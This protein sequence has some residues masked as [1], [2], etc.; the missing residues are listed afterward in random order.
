IDQVVQK[1]TLNTE[2]ERAFMIIANHYLTA[3]QSPLQLYMAGMAG[4]GKSRVIHALSAFFTVMDASSQLLL[5]APTGTA[6]ANIGGS[7]YHSVLGINPRSKSIQ[8]LSL[9]AR[10]SLERVRYIFIDEVSMI[11][12]SDMKTISER[13]AL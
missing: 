3:S 9:N 5:L 12:C 11:S 10:N 4:T 7:T 2:Q 1:F 6:A 13:L 8:K